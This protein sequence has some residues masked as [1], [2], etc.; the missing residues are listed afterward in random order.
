MGKTHSPLLG[1]NN[2]VRH[3]NRVFHIQTEDS[4]VKH[5]HIITHLFMDGGRIL[6]SVK[7]SYAEHVGTDGMQDTVRQMMKEQHKAMFIALR[8]GQFDAVVDEQVASKAKYDADTSAKKSK[9]IAPGGSAA[10]SPAAPAVA[11]V[12]STTAPGVGQITHATTAGLAPPAA[13][14]APGATAASPASAP[15][16]TDVE[17]KGADTKRESVSPMQ[18]AAQ[19]DRVAPPPTPAVP[20]DTQKMGSTAVGMSTGPGVAAR[21]QSSVPPKSAPKSVPAAAAAK[22]GDV[23][24]PRYPTP[25]KQRLVVLPETDEA[26]PNTMRDPEPIGSRPP[27]LEIDLNNSPQPPRMVPDADLF[28]ANDLPPPPQNLFKRKDLTDRSTYRGAG[29]EERTRPK[30][31]PPPK[32]PQRRSQP[33]PL[34]PAAQAAPTTPNVPPVTRGRPVAPLP[35]SPS[36]SASTSGMQAR[37]GAGRSGSP[38]SAPAR[39]A[40]ARPATIFGAPRGKASLFGDDLVTDKSL[41]EVILSYLAEDLEQAPKKK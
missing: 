17:V 2:N 27:P 25:G 30:S 28:R 16:S 35:N 38:S 39:Y 4:G 9:S 26:Q 12:P 7:K 19:V 1:F 41:D 33:P 22:T 18:A 32:P 13:G 11:G 24:E 6:K 23:G 8:D 37:D 21:R 31:V 34:S 20:T 14:S 29:E 40:P 15:P 3:K 36:G 10:A 5:P